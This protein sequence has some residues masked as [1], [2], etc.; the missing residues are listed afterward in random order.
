MKIDIPNAV[1]V[2]DRILAG[3]QPDEAQLRQA[4]AAGF[5]TIVNLR[6]AGETGSLDNE[7]ELVGSL[8]MKYVA[9]PI[10]GATG[11][12]AESA[13]KLADSL[14]GSE[15]LPAMV[16]CASG[17]RVGYLFALKAFVVDGLD[18]GEALAFG[19]A[20]GMRRESA[21]LEELLASDPRD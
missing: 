21:R 15:A 9:I 16:H 1:M 10:A 7:A 2:S 11:L 19:K 4:A 17:N 8:N 12:N 3:G 6:G 5:K 14:A 18:G 13:R 20:V